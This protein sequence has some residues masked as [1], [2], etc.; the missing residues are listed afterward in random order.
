MV[1]NIINEAKFWHWVLILFIV[2]IPIGVNLSL[3]KDKCDSP[4]IKIGNTWSEP[5]KVDK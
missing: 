2:L 1:K 5:L 3:N 4:K